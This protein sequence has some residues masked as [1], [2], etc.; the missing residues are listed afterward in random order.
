ML[1]SAPGIVRNSIS[2]RGLSSMSPG[3]KTLAIRLLCAFVG[4][5]LSQQPSGASD[6][7]PKHSQ[8]RVANVH[9]G[10]KSKPFA[11][12]TD[13]RVQQNLPTPFRSEASSLLFPATVSTTIQQ[14]DQTSANSSERPS[15]N[16]DSDLQSRLEVLEA[17]F[18]DLSTSYDPETATALTARLNQ[19]EE[20]MGVLPAGGIEFLESLSG[21]SKRVFNGRLHL[22]AWQFPNAT[23]GINAIE[24]GDFAVDPENRVL[25]RRARISVQGTV[26]PDNMSYR[27]DLEFS[28][29]D[30]G[31]IRDAWLAWDDLPILNTLRIGNQKRPY[32][33]DHLNSS[34]TITFLERPNIVDAA[35]RENRRIG[36]ASYSASEGQAVNWQFGLFNM[37][38]IQD[39]NQ[40]VGDEAQTE[41]AGR[42]TNTPWYDECSAGRN[43]VHAGLAGTLAFPGGATP[44]NQAF[45]RSRP[46]ARSGAPWLDTGVIAG[47]ESYQLIAIESVINVGPLQLVS[48]AMHIQMQ[49]EAGFGPDLSFRG[50]YVSLSYFLTGEHI[51]WNRKLG[52][53]GRIEPH[54]NFFCVRDS[55]GN[56][57]RGLGAWQ[58]AMRLSRA[59]FND[60]DVFGG[61]GESL[62]LALN[63]YWNSHTRLQCNYIFGQIDN[64]RTTLTNGMTPIVSGEYQTIGTRFMI[65]F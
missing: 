34:N 15:E 45:F 49:R 27:L 18:R 19:I 8:N 1:D 22:D 20:T 42:L 31:Q 43:Y 35:N 30:G 2:G 4:V 40:I 23:P 11:A 65:D 17:G 25:V 57:G 58:V 5:C 24:S 21:A 52:I 62:S 12:P 28:G 41:L 51:P 60:K 7:K 26:P 53:Q 38:T 44:E 33:L 10:D 50:G 16:A 9:Y 37:V 13:I 54:E 63:W 61:L 47:S 6:F 14:D 55:N 39:T 64:R 48:E 29:T 46:E 59:D 36:L 32:G 56:R 3:R